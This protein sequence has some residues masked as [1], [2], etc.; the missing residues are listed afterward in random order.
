MNQ[1][2]NL[3]GIMNEIVE[4]SD[5]SKRVLFSDIVDERILKVCE[6][7]ENEHQRPVLV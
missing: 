4:K 5:D 7:L 1:E 3:W 6:I 2:K